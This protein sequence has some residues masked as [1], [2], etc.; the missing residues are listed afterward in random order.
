M[1]TSHV[2]VGCLVARDLDELYGAQHRD[3]DQLEGN[4]HIK[5]QSEGVPRGVVTQCVVDDIAG[6]IGRG[7]QRIDICIMLVD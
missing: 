7:G 2:L 3:P 5:N 6:S 4:P 1:V